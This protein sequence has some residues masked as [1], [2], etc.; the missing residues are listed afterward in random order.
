MVGVA[1]LMLR[2]GGPASFASDASFQLSA[3]C[4]YDESLWPP[5]PP[6][7]RWVLGPRHAVISKQGLPPPSGTSQVNP[8]HPGKLVSPR[9]TRAW[10]WNPLGH[11]CPLPMGPWK[12]LGELGFLLTTGRGDNAGSDRPGNFPLMFGNLRKRELVSPSASLGM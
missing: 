6:S 3:I 11:V 7:R 12:V 10:A 4:V 2:A 9:K 1:C 5:Q 8:C